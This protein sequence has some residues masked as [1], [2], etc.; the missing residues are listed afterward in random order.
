VEI[1]L[2]LGGIRAELH[3]V[4][5][6]HLALVRR[7]GWNATSYQ[8]LEPGYR[9]LFVDGSACV[10]FVDITPT[11]TGHGYWLVDRNGLVFAFGDAVLYGSRQSPC[12]AAFEIHPAPGGAPD[13]GVG[14][15]GLILLDD[16]E[17]AWLFRKPRDTNAEGPRVE[18]RN[19]SCRFEPAL[20]L[21]PEIL[22]APEALAPKR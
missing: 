20:E 6:E 4:A 8:V 5:C 1:E 3:V 22:D 10:A 16:L 21:P 13:P 17:H 9:Y 12:A 2:V 11:T 7:F 15:G 18:Y 19:M 14:E